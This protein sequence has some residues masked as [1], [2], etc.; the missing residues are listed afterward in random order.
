MGEQE[1]YELVMKVV[2]EDEVKNLTKA[3]E[4]AEAELKKSVAALGTVDAAALRADASVQVFSGQISDLKQ[5]L[6]R[7][8]NNLKSVGSSTKNLNQ[9]MSSAGYA[10]DDLQ[11]GFKGISNNIQPIL[12]TI[13]AL[14]G[15]AGPISAAAILVYQ[16]YEHWDQ[17]MKAFGMGATKTQAEEMEDLG[18][19]THKTADETEKLAKWEERRKTIASQQNDAT[20]AEAAQRAAAHD[21]IVEGP[22]NTV[23]QAVTKIDRPALEKAVPQDLQTPL[24]DLKQG[25]DR[26]KKAFGPNHSILPEIQ[27]EIDAAQ[28]KIDDW[29]EDQISG[30]VAGIE[31]DPKTRETFRK[32]IA[33]NPMLLGGSDNT[34]RFLD[35]TK[36]PEQKEAEHDAEGVQYDQDQDTAHE[37]KK[38]EAE[39][40]IL[41]ADKKILDE[42]DKEVAEIV[43]GVAQDIADQDFKDRHAALQKKE[44]D[45]KA[46]RKDAQDQAKQA[47]GDT[48]GLKDDIQT[49]LLKR[50][51]GG[52][53]NRQAQAELSGEI[54]A[55]LRES[56]VSGA[57]AAALAKE[58]V[59]NANKSLMEDL[60]KPQQAKNSEVLGA[61]ASFAEKIQSSISSDNTQK[62]QLEQLKELVRLARSGRQP[63]PTFQ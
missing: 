17:L 63:I 20:K 49:E 48:P 62:S 40:K 3:L 16:L 22:Y 43:A 13:P 14:A 39:K 60:N 37:Y 33:D 56:G 58:Q 46:V 10:V 18:K 29:I 26:A 28:K 38:Y 7:A 5:Q 23:R 31:K 27:K 47:L 51:M 8:E 42:K 24:D 52:Q 25:L 57:D 15:L 1:T 50:Q 44:D 54:A 35:A 61:G 11:Y 53:N 12:Q 30:K 59:G 2:G 32:N 9:F 41:E 6:E 36:S 4:L 34:D 21:A 45:A 55:K 19:K